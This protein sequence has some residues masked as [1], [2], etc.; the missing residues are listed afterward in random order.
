MPGWIGPRTKFQS[1]H[2]RGVRQYD[3]MGEGLTPEISIHA[4]AWGATVLVVFRN[5]KVAFQSTHP[6]GV[7]RYLPCDQLHPDHDFNPRTRVGCDLGASGWSWSDT[8]FNP[9]T[10][11]GCDT[12]TMIVGDRGTDFNPRTRVGCDLPPE[13]VYQAMVRISIHAP[14]W[15]A[16]RK[17]K[18]IMNVFV[19]QSTH[20]RGVRLLRKFF[21]WPCIDFNPRTRVGCDSST[22]LFLLSFDISIHAPAWGATCCRSKRK[23]RL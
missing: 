14:A 18:P 10:R 7:R 22:T 20:P 15:G 19:F 5:Q 11:V 12:C 4:P 3:I 16:T 17:G 8:Y 6:R 21:G 9:R 2:P 1:T 13:R 23:T